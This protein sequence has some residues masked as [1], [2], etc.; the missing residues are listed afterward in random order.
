MQR[1]GCIR[2]TADEAAVYDSVDDIAG[3]A[4]R[5]DLET[6]A[7]DVLRRGAWHVEIV[8]PDGAVVWTFDRADY[9]NTLTEIYP[10]HRF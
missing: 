7:R 5:A 6:R 4:L 3:R 9:P 1:I 10:R 2:L 8:H